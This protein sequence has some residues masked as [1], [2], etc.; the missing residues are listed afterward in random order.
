MTVLS[1]EFIRNSMLNSG[2]FGHELITRVQRTC[3]QPLSTMENLKWLPREWSRFSSAA[4]AADEAPN[5][6][7]Q[8]MWV[9]RLCDMDLKAREED[10]PLVFP[11]GKGREGDRR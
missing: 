8:I 9:H 1:V 10:T 5:H 11:L 4:G 2:R 7:S 3:I 6:C